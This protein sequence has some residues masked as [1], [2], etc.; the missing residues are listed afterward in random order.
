MINVNPLPLYR[1][2]YG[3]SLFQNPDSRFQEYRKRWETQPLEFASGDFPLFLDIEVTNICNLRCAFCAT[4]YFG[5][6]VKRQLIDD[7]IVYR[8]LDEGKAKGLYGVKFN[9]R[10]EPLI[11]P[12]LASYVRYAKECGLVDVYFNTNAML[13]TEERSAEL[14]DAGLDRISISI[15]GATAEIYEKHRRGGIFDTVVANVRSLHG[16]RERRGSNFPKIRIQTVA[17]PEVEADLQ[18]YIDFWKPYCDEIAA[19][20]FKEESSEEKRLLD[21]PFPWACHQ[22]W[23]RMVVWCDGTILPCNEDDRGMLSLG[24]VKTTTI[25]DAWNSSSLQLLRKNHSMGNAHVSKPCNGCYLRDSQIKK[26][27]SME[28][29]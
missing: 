27:R 25:G 2:L 20:D 14:I 21:Y 1:N 9:D 18:T 4:T 11:H 15:E 6:E 29:S 16:L 7:D 8:V 5:P 23:Q 28:A 22:L 12:R 24:N 3:R 17:L 19:I 26:I 10:G 13:L